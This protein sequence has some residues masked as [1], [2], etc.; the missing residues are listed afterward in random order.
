R[1]P[2]ISKFKSG[3]D[4]PLPSAS[5]YT[6]F[7]RASIATEH[8]LCSEIGRDVMVIGGNAIDASI[9]SLL[10][11][12][13]VNP[14]S[15]GLGGG[16]IMTIFNKST[17]RCVSI[18]ARETAPS[19][20]TGDMYSANPSD[21]SHGYSSIGVPGELH[22][23]Y[24]AFTR[25]GSGKVPWKRLVDPSASLAARGFPVSKDLVMALKYRE[26]SMNLNEDMVE[27]FTN[28]ETGMQYEEGDIMKRHKLAN[29]LKL[30]A[31]STDPI[32]LFYRHGMAQSIAA[33]FE[34][35]GEYITEQDLEN[36][37]THVEE[38]PLV[39]S[40]LSGG[41]S[42]CGPPPPSSFVIVQAIVRTMARFY[43]GTEMSMDDPLVYHRMIEAMKFAFAQRSK[44]G[45]VKVE[46]A[47]RDVVADMITPD[48]ISSLVGKIKDHA[49]SMED[50][51]DTPMSIS[52]DHGANQ[53]SAIDKEGN[54]VSCSEQVNHFFG[55]AA[56]S[57]TLGIFWNDQMD[58]FSK[59]SDDSELG[60]PPSKANFIAPG[61]RPMSSLSPTIVYS[62]EGEVKM[63]AGASGGSL[64][65][66]S[67]AQSIINSLL[68][69]MTAKEAVDAP[70]FH[71][72]FLPFT[73]YYEDSLPAEI[74]DALRK[75]YHQNMTTTERLP[76]VV[77]ALKV[78]ED[79]YIHGNSDWRHSSINTYPSGF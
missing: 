28:P 45:D 76:G 61:K 64:I 63:V 72:Q 3:L 40:D 31:E 37:E 22:G 46:E 29:T 23:L 44:L 5:M 74:V 1:N 25:F 56:L 17:G 43:N 42:M 34:R 62:K 10:C 35:N 2:F 47:A 15:S 27:L 77:Q 52:E 38:N 78:G 73:C 13:V 16:F 6:S 60:F 21:S 65:I 11:T 48:L 4:W 7:R 70:R 41:L 30:I 58:A 33:E 14:Q 67:V 19:S 59:P 24:T 36:Y 69:N 55:S 79:R 71:H 32:G 18:D 9:A 54:A 26:K 50:Y 68:L 75:R 51:T 66:S 57:P 53:I 20:A 8:D 49:L 12:G 39:V